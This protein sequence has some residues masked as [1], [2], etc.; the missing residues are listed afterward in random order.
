MK[1]LLIILS[2]ILPPLAVYLATKCVKTTLINLILCFVF[3]LPGVVHALW[4]VFKSGAP[5]AA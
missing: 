1:I 3:Y 5:Q 4:T 2:L